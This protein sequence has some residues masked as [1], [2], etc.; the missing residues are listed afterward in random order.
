LFEDEIAD[1]PP[2]T[3]ACCSGCLQRAANKSWLGQ[4][5]AL[6]RGLSPPSCP[7]LGCAMP[8]LRAVC[9]A[10]HCVALK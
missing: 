1:S 6:C 5:R 7:P 3:Y 2:R 8:I 4:F 9:Q 10:G